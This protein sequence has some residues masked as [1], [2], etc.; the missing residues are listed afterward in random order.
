MGS[1][2]YAK[3]EAGISAMRISRLARSVKRQRL[4]YLSYA[5]LRRLENALAETLALR[6]DGT[7]LE[8]GVALGG[9]AVLIAEAASRAHQ[10]FIGFDVFG[11]IPPPTSDKDDEAS[12]ARYRT[13]ASG[14]AAGIDG[15]LYYGYRTSLY[16]DVVTAFE[17]N[18]LAVDGRRISLVKGLFEDTWPD[19]DIRSVA[20]CHI[21]CDWYDPVRFCLQQVAPRL[22]SGGRILLDDYHDYG[23][24]LE[25]TDEF[26]RVHPEFELLD[27][28]NVILRRRA[29]VTQQTP[30]LESTN[31]SGP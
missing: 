4:T 17:R 29:G 25:A 6:A 2:M 12:K 21:D 7:F 20:F 31:S 30:H 24:C 22:A 8:F 16:D 18:G 5:K 23:G 3:F 9:S 10:A 19:V 15:D 27:G 26:L 28:P 13:I 11:L 1:S 14:E